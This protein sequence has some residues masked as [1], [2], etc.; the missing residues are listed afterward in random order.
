MVSVILLYPSTIIIHHAVLGPL[1][2]VE[3][4]GLDRPKE[5]EPACETD[6]EHENDERDDRPEHKV[7]SQFKFENWIPASAGMT[8]LCL[9]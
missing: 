3:L 7:K 8:D 9:F 6:E 4:A 5:D 1:D 2:I